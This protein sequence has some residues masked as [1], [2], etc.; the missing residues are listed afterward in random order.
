MSAL[1]PHV[2]LALPWATA[3]LAEAHAKGAQPKLS[4]CAWL[5]GRGAPIH[6]ADP[7]RAWL[8]NA[9]GDAS[10]LELDACPPGPCLAASLGVDEAGAGTWAVA[11]PVHLA[12]G[13]DHLRLAPL[14]EAAPSTDEATQ[15]GNT[16][17]SHFA[18]HAF[19]L[20]DFVDGAWL[21]RLGEPLEV[22]THEPGGLVGQ[23][24]H[25]AM[26]AGRDGVRVRSWMNELQMLLHEHP[27]NQRRVQRRALPINALWLWGF[28]R[29][30][31]RP[32][33]PA[34]ALSRWE[35]RSDDLWLR[36]LWRLHGG[37]ERA[38]GDPSFDTANTLIAMTQPPTADPVEALLE[39]D[40]SLLARLR[41]A[42]LA[43]RVSG[44]DVWLGRRA[45]R[46]DRRARWQLWRRPAQLSSL[47]SE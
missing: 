29:G 14:A 47:I 15:L 20:G 22:A 28:G 10:G 1:R 30:R 16:L 39:I 45:F 17:R 27:V 25:D 36:A 46:L 3:A 34:A 13:L 5:A 41:E 35:L 8:L 43:R 18:G 24:I 19:E 32:P 44:L 40:S 2:R 37:R 38:L 11:Q 23:D 42:L 26:P 21:L 6:V 31:A 33:A 12:A 7:W 4:S 9:L